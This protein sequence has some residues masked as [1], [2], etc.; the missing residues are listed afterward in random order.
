MLQ[1]LCIHFYF[2]NYFDYAIDLGADLGYHKAQI[3]LGN[4]IVTIKM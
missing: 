2:K 4:D 1:L 3:L